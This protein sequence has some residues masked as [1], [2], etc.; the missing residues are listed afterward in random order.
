MSLDP[1][2][3][4]KRSHCIHYNPVSHGLVNAPKDWAYSSFHRVVRW[5]VYPEDGGTTGQIAGLNGR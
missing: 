4:I 3:T 2:D 1:T 5:G